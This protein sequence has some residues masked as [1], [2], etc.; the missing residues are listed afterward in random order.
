VSGHTLGWLRRARRARR[1]VRAAR[2]LAG[3]FVLCE[4]LR[5]WVFTGFPWLSM[6]YAEIL[7]AGR[8][9]LAGYAPVGGVFLVR[10]RSRICAACVTRHH[11]R[12]RDAQP[13]RSSP[14]SASPRSSRSAAPRC[15]AVEWTQPRVARR[16]VALQGNV[17]QADK[18]DPAFRPRNYELYE[19]SCARARDASS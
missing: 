18:F 16:R 10:S 3:A 5:G 8:L 17:S 15:C 1:E 7:A 14:A 4:W 19:T 12:R 2:R 13:R 6:G 9:P 11:A